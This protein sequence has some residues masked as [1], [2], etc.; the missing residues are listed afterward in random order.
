MVS[1]KRLVQA[2]GKTKVVK[3]VAEPFE[4]GY[5]YTYKYKGLE[6]SFSARFCENTEVKGP[7]YIFY[8]NGKAYTVGD[9]IEKLKRNFPVL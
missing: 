5:A 9:R 8:L 6:V 3:E 7:E 1:R 4:G 2:F